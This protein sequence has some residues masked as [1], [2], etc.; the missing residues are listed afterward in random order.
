MQSHA[1]HSLRAPQKGPP[2]ASF[3]AR[4]TMGRR[5]SKHLGAFFVFAGD[6]QVS[7]Q[8]TAVAVEKTTCGRH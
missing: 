5:T 2:A 1:S 4:K 3:A 8:D 7:S 6:V